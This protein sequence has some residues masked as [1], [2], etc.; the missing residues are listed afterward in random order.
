MRHD[1]VVVVESKPNLSSLQEILRQSKAVSAT[2]QQMLGDPDGAALIRK[3]QEVLDK[4][5]RNGQH[6]VA[7]E[8]PP[9]SRPTCWKRRATCA[10]RKRCPTT[11]NATPFRLSLTNFTGRADRSHHSLP[12]VPDHLATHRRSVMICYPASSSNEHVSPSSSN[13]NL[14]CQ[15]WLA[16]S[17]RCTD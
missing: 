9:P 17:F 14:C 11:L 7:E 15:P 13:T 1:I 16:G 6:E 12:W 3:A 8:A 2:T 5:L 4:A 10:R